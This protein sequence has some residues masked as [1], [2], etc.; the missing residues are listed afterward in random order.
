MAHVNVVQIAWLVS[1]YGVF[2]C[3]CSPVAQHGT[4][5]PQQ[6]VAGFGLCE[7][8]CC[9]AGS[10]AGGKFVARRIESVR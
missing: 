9:A 6:A 5:L 8:S 10:H 4:H 2:A 7:K 1:Q 3:C